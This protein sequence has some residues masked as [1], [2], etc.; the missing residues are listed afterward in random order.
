MRAISSRR[1][2]LATMVG[3][4]LEWYD[5]AIYGY[6]AATIGLQF[7]PS[8]NPAVS[9]IAA[10]G[11]FATGFLARPVGAVLFGNLGDR[12]GRHRV[13]IVSILVMAGPTALVGALPTY[14]DI[15]VWAPA[16]L[17][18]LR[19]LQ[20]LSVG[21]EF[22]GSITYMVEGAPVQRRG[23]AGSWSFFG[24][25]AGFLLGSGAGSLVTGLLDESSVADWGWRIPF[26]CGALLAL[27]GYF[28]RRHALAESYQPQDTDVPWYKGPLREAVTA[29]GRQM[30]QAIGIAAF[31]ASGFYL[32]FVYLTTYITRVVGDPAADAFEINSI[33]IVFYA[34][35]VVV[36]GLLGDRFG[37]RRVLLVTAVA[38]L[39]LAWPMFWL[40]DH[41]DPLLSFL[42][43]FGYVLAVAP[44]SG[45][46]ATSMALL[47][48]P[49]VRMSGFS[50]SYNIGLA[51]LGGTAPLVVSYLIDR[52]AGDM[53]PAY[54]LMVS[55]VISIVTLI[56]AWRDLPGRQ[57][58]RTGG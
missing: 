54:V 26:L 58:A 8:D 19:L 48:P 50:I 21:G 9:V 11:V 30:I 18:L 51:A 36:G 37:S 5:F 42:G 38:G 40:I 15:G 55:A 29:H 3:N 27:C 1:I 35:L 46:F 57:V 31:S 53:S 43:Q 23:L 45:L 39:I 20:G 6:F 32:M 47:F 49:N 12:V 24:V 34:A 44:Y 28:I 52:D 10:F 25:G 41:P 16:L 22:T 33:N 17:I 4:I 7:F 13:L 14:D 2:R 56:W